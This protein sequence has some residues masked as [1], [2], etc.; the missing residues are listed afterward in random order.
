M[1]DT[2]EL[3]NTCTHAYKIYIIYINLYKNNFI[4]TIKNNVGCFMSDKGKSEFV[5]RSM[6]KMFFNFAL[7]TV[8]HSANSREKN[9]DKRMF[10]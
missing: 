8:Y 10:A 3:Y 2:K 7:A 1:F 5:K 4:T 9:C 6:F